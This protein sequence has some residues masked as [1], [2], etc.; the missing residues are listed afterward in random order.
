MFSPTINVPLTVP[1]SSLFV[2]EFQDFTLAVTP[3]IEPVTTS[4]YSYVPEPV[5]FGFTILTV[6]AIVYP[7][8]AFV[9]RIEVTDP[10][11]LMTAVPVAD[12][13][14]TPVNITLGDVE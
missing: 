5:R 6:G 10:P 12:A 13:I 9:I 1:I 2:T 7:N 11:A 8:P 14:P 3:L 4:L